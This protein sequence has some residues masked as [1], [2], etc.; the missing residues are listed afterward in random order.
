M[1]LR[2]DREENLQI[3]RFGQEILDNGKTGEILRN[4]KK[5]EN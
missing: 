4:G 1:D 3:D 2:K 5:D